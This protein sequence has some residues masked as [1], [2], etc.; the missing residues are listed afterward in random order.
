MDSCSESEDK[1][2]LLIV[3]TVSL[4]FIYITKAPKILVT[5]C[6]SMYHLFSCQ[7]ATFQALCHCSILVL[8]FNSVSNGE[9]L[10]WS[11]SYKFDHRLSLL[12]QG[13]V[14]PNSKMSTSSPT[15][16]NEQPTWCCASARSRFQTWFTRPKLNTRR[17][18]FR[19]F[20]IKTSTMSTE[21]QEGMPPELPQS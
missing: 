4:E 11:T 12:K 6:I 19:K 17:L 14:R 7:A 13:H 5:F 15:T 10:K 18:H 20:C 1:L 8:S 21:Q 2:F 16:T 3:I 9:Q